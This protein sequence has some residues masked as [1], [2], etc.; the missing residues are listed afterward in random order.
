MRIFILYLLF[1]CS[2]LT[3]SA[4][5]PKNELY[6]LI[7]KLINDSTGYEN[8]GDWAVGQPKKFP[9]K[10]NEDRII[11]SEDTSINF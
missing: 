8:V 11:M 10:W 4:Q 1:T 6:D 3:A 9:V 7:K 5:S 2:A